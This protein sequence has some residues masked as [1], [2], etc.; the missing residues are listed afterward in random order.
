[1][2][3][4]H[5][6]SAHAAHAAHDDFDPEPP[7]RLSPGETPS[8]WWLPIL[9]VTFFTVAA[10]MALASG[11]EEAAASD[12]VAPAA[13]VEGA[14]PAEAAAP[15]EDAREKAIN[16]ARKLTPEQIDAIRKRMPPQPAP[17]AQ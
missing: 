8:P 16:I 7:T 1:M 17:A 11:G 14:A 3:N 10:L 4:T 13:L 15:S 12:A 9:G 5:E 2:S 6:A